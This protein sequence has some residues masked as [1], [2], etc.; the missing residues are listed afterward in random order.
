MGTAYIVR[1]TKNGVESDYQRFE[2]KPAAYR[3]VAELQRFYAARVVERFEADPLGP[4]LWEQICYSRRV[5]A[6]LGALAAAAILFGLAML[7]RGSK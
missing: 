7:L 6:V 2:Q 3:C 4:T 1:V 5:R